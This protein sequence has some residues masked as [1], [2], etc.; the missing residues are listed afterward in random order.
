M[1]QQIRD[2]KSIESLEQSLDR[3]Y[4]WIG[5][6]DQKAG[7]LLATIGVI[8]T[9]LFT[10]DFMKEVKIAVIK[11]FLEYWGNQG[12][13]EF[14]LLN[15]LFSICFAA[16]IVLSII[17]AIYALRSISATIDSKK[18][19]SD[20]PNVVNKSFLFFQTISFMTYDEFKNHEGADYQLDLLSQIYIN[21]KICTKK[22]ESYQTALRFFYVVVI[23]LALMFIFYLFMH[24]E[25]N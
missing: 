21:S 6:C 25:G 7:F 19:I 12:D 18:I 13:I 14:C 24:Y 8:M 3:V 17:S 4:M 15:F 2:H 9:I 5:N 10:S 20:N 23:C 1:C 16:T 22:F 11:P